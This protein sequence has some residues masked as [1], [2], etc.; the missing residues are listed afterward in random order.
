MKICDLLSIEM[1]PPL[2]NAIAL[3]CLTQTVSSLKI[4]P[5]SLARLDSP[6][7]LKSSF[8]NAEL[9]YMILLYLNRR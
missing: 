8:A 9:D 4:L 7:F 5:V 6:A 3:L 2:G 1:L